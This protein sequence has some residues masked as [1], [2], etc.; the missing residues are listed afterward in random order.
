METAR[1][2][3]KQG[4]KY[5]KKLRLPSISRFWPFSK[6]ES[7]EEDVVED[8]EVIEEDA[9]VLEEEVEEEVE[10][11]E[12]EVAEDTEEA[13]EEGT[14]SSFFSTTGMNPMVAIVINIILI[15][16]YYIFIFILASIVA[17]DYIRSHWLIRLYAFIFVLILCYYT[18]LGVY[19][20]TTYYSLKALYNV[21][22]NYR[23][24]PLDPEALKL[25]HPRTILPLR[26]CFLPLMTTRSQGI[27][28]MLNPFSYFAKGEDPQD[29]VYANY[30]YES[31][32]Y[33]TKINSRI[34]GFTE[35]K[36]MYLGTLLKKFSRFFYEINE[37]YLKKEPQD[38][39]EVPIK[40]DLN[41]K[42]TL[43][44][45]FAGA[46]DNPIEFVQKTLGPMPVPMTPTTTTATAT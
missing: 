17:N 31:K 40:D 38:E 11:V 1:Y 9:E 20:I 14:G 32:K 35:L 4:I 13:T 23:D 37:S 29:P 10:E 7:F 45:A 25:W 2:V 34:P 8:E 18:S 22:R 39:E 24:K 12:E 6:R 19:P 27:L 28:D 42:D 30:K 41:L 15:A 26:Y 16:L 43:K 3:Y 33:I 36:G 46:T 5:I 44:G 21:Y